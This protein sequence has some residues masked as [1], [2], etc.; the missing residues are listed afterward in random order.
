MALSYDIGWGFRAGTRFFFETGRP[1]DTQCPNATCKPGDD[2]ALVFPASGTLPAF[3]RLDVRLEKRWTFAGSRWITASIE[4]FNATNNAEPISA[5]YSPASGLG[6]DTQPPV[7]L[8]S[9]GVEAG[10]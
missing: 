1:Y 4:C 8:P 3:Y 6:I 2:A 5:S 10:F 9:I 7:I